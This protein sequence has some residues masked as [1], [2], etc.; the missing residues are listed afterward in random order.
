MVILSSS[1]EPSVA[2]TSMPSVLTFHDAHSQNKSEEVAL[3]IILGFL[4]LSIILYFVAKRRHQKYI[5]LDI[6]D[7]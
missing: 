2:L 6:E 3:F 4:L 5:I 1:A 7:I